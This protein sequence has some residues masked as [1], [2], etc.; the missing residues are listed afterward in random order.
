[1]SGS[2][3]LGAER[4]VRA[5]GLGNRALAPQV[6]IEARIAP[7]RGQILVTERLAP[8]LQLPTA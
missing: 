3:R 8:D 6:G 7:L 4:I 2:E 5:A 1:M